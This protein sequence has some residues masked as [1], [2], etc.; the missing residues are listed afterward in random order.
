MIT[1]SPDGTRYEWQHYR[2]GGKYST[3]TAIITMLKVDPI[4]PAADDRGNTFELVD[5]NSP[6]YRQ[7][8]TR[9]QIGMYPSLR[10]A[11]EAAMARIPWRLDLPGKNRWLRGN[12]AIVC[13][14]IKGSRLWTWCVDGELVLEHTDGAVLQV[15]ADQYFAGIH[16]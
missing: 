1:H 11:Q 9:P 8:G 2:I 13:R 6:A 3:S 16:R 7:R 15:L 10:E 4:H 14:V 12:M 5:R